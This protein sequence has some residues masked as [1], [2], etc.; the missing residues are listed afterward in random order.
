MSSLKHIH[1]YVKWRKRGHPAEQ[2]W[3]CAHPECTHTIAQS[4]IVG[5]QTMCPE[6][7]KTIFI[8]DW[9]DDLLRRAVPK[10]INCRNTASAKEHQSVKSL[11]VDLFKDQEKVGEGEKV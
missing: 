6:C 8:L 7:F 11:V 9:K 1:S 4:L 2:Y 5:K 10:C 3:K